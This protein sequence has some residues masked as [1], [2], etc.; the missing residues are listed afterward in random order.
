AMFDSKPM[1]PSSR[2]S[3][4]LASTASTYT[5]HEAIECVGFGRFQIIMSIL[6]GFAW[7][8][9]SM[10]VMLLSLLTPALVCEW[11]IT[12]AQ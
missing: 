2:S 6:A 5:V 1:T 7:M 10:E 3:K 9:D 11:G 12:P 4:S 8:A